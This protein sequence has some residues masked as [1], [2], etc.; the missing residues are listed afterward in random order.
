MAFHWTMGKMNLRMNKKFTHP[1][2]LSYIPEMQIQFNTHKLKNAIYNVNRLKERNNVFIT[3]DAEK[4]FDKI[5]YFIMIKV[6]ENL[7]LQGVCINILKA[8]YS[9]LIINKILN[10]RNSNIS[11][12]INKTRMSTISIPFNIVIEVLVKIKQV[13][14]IKEV[15]IKEEVKA[16]LFA[17]DMILSI[18]DQKTPAAAKYT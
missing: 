11:T 13:M 5:Q 8:I 9:K 16:S 2:H 18:K 17:D 15:Q 12:K 4:A 10:R 7:G 1:D 3:L 6:P 14:E